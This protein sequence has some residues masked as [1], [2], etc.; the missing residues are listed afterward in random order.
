MKVVIYFLTVKGT[1][2][3]VQPED[4][5]ACVLVLTLD[6]ATFCWEALNAHR[7]RWVVEVSNLEIKDRG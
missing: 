1:H 3:V 6:S 4:E 7:V 5:V 2:T